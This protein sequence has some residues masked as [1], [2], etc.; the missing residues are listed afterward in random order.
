MAL[1]LKIPRYRA[2]IH[3]VYDMYEVFAI[4]QMAD[5]L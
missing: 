2:T 4:S 3:G 1:F 5:M